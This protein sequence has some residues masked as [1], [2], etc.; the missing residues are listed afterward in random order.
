M[1]IILLQLNL[2]IYSE[3]WLIKQRIGN[4]VLILLNT[5]HILHI[6][7]EHSRDYKQIRAYIWVHV[8]LRRKQC[9]CYKQKLHWNVANAHF[10]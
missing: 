10:D 9:K 6:D 1:L 7:I 5:P 2:E 8:N 4:V 3:Y